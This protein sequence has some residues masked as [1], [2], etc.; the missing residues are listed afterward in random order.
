LPLGFCARVEAYVVTRFRIARLLFA[1][2][3]CALLGASVEAKLSLYHAAHTPGANI[4]QVIKL[5]EVRIGP[6]A[7]E[8]EVPVEVA[9]EVTPP[10]V[11]RWLPVSPPLRVSPGS[12]PS[13]PQSHWFRP[14]PSIS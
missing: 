10:R 2:L 5:R 11:N 7:L 13:V 12:G 3:A 8:V 1:L 9:C 4:S 14:P 6:V